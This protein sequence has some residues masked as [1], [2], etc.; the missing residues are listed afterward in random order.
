MLISW[1]DCRSEVNSTT[2]LRCIHLLS[3]IVI[4]DQRTKNKTIKKCTNLKCGVRYLKTDGD[5]SSTVILL[6][7]I[8]TLNCR[9]LASMMFWS[10]DMPLT[11]LKRHTTLSG[12]LDREDVLDLGRERESLDQMLFFGDAFRFL[13]WAV[14]FEKDALRWLTPLL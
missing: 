6:R 12:M 11:S 3:L 1:L 2:S 4:F 14:F 9:I 10:R 13:S 8:P 5:F 7:S